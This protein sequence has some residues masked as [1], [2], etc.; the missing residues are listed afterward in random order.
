MGC[1]TSGNLFGNIEMRAE[2]REERNAIEGCDVFGREERRD[3]PGS[4]VEK[5]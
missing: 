4:W 2:T 1:R 5:E 3:C